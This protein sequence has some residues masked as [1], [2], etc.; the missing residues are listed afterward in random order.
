[1][2]AM[3]A[4]VV[5]VVAPA[6]ATTTGLASS[7]TN[8][9]LPCGAAAT[10]DGMEPTVV[11]NH[12][13]P[14]FVVESDSHYFFLSFFL[15]FSVLGTETCVN[16]CNSHGSCEPPNQSHSKYWCNCE[17]GW[18]GANC[19]RWP[20]FESRLASTLIVGIRHRNLP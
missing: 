13:F 12:S 18:N 19:G 9:T 17:S 5:M 7:R 11:R 20:L 1:M 16:N 8:L 4:M 3:V 15:S 6:T 10:A 2:V 14:H